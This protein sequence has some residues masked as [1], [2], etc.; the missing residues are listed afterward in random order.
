L[1]HVA[2]DKFP[3]YWRGREGGI[4]AETWALDKNINITRERE[5]LIFVECLENAWFLTESD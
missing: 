3:Y 4:I 2:V 1:A 5:N